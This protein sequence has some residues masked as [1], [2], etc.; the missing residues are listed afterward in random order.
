M[1]DDRADDYPPTRPVITCGVEVST[2]TSPPFSKI[3]QTCTSSR[4]CSTWSAASRANSASVTRSTSDISEASTLTKLSN[5]THASIASGRRVTMETT[6]AAT[7]S[8]SGRSP[9]AASICAALRGI[10]FLPWPSRQIN[11]RVSHVSRAKDLR[12]STQ[13]S[14]LLAELGA[15]LAE[16]AANGFDQEFSR[17][18]CGGQHKRTGYGHIS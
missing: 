7:L 9:N 3:N 15:H 18:R 13:R 12:V 8:S 11:N 4:R 1:S 6:S 10:G 14:Q 2:E 16:R 17:I 5:E